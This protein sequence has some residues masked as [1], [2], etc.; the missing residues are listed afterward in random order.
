M[1]A[2]EKAAIRHGGGANHRFGLD[3]AILIKDNHVAVAGGIRR[4][5]KRRAHTRAIS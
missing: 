3:D 5:S 4:P 1:R 2:L